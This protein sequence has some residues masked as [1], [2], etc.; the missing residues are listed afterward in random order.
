MSF[1]D[2]PFRGRHDTQHRPSLCTSLLS[3]FTYPR[4]H[5]RATQRYRSTFHRVSAPSPTH[6]GYWM[7]TQTA[8]L[9][10]VTS[11]SL[12]LAHLCYGPLQ[13]VHPTRKLGARHRFLRFTSTFINYAAARSPTLIPSQLYAM[14]EGRIWTH[15]CAEYMC[16]NRGA[17]YQITRNRLIRDALS[18]VHKVTTRLIERPSTCLRYQVPR[19]LL[20]L[21]RAESPTV[22]G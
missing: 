5:F 11:S 6:V 3:T 19:C 7:I 8:V 20:T 18:S 2:P 1:Q 21:R 9:Y 10:P 12:V 4:S 16:S 14:R 22:E 15:L 17:F 13:L